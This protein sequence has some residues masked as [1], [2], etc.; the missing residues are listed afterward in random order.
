MK[1]EEIMKRTYGSREHV[2]SQLLYSVATTP[3][4]P[5]GKPAP[6]MQVNYMSVEPGNGAEYEQLE[7]EIWLPIHNESIRSGR[8]SGWSLWST[9]FPRGAACP[10]QYMTLN[11]FSEFSYVF[12]LDFSI[13]FGNIHPDKDFA[14]TQEKT[15]ELRRIVHAEL[16]DLI[17]YVIR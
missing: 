4:I 8:T 9:L 3:E 17:D 16:W 11:S 1:M 14:Q 10:Y 13:P 6:Y 5:L 2:H 12:E 7:S 15:R